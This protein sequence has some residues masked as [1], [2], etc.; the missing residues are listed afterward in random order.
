M[1]LYI[2]PLL[3]LLSAR[4]FAQTNSEAY[5]CVGAIGSTEATKAVGE[6]VS[7]CW[8]TPY[9][10]K[11]RYFRVRR[12][13]SQEGFYDVI[14]AASKLFLTSCWRETTADSD[15]IYGTFSFKAVRSYHY[16]VT[17]IWEDTD[18]QGNKF[19]H[20]TTG[21]QHAKVTVK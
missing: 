20:E 14:I 11:F 1:K 16:F 13:Q 17:T 9:S 2:F 15:M 19:L 3:L 18:A 21:S 10:D 4:A 12:S 7:L 5:L 6:D 8:E